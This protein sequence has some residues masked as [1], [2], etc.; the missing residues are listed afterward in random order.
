MIGVTGK[1][2]GQGIDSKVVVLKGQCRAPCS[3]YPKSFTG[4]RSFLL[5][6]VQLLVF[7]RLLLSNLWK[8]VGQ[9][10][11]GKSVSNGL[12]MVA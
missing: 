5:P 6:A 10:F 4:C 7:E 3:F 12:A 1:G 8:R 2:R 11:A 9:L